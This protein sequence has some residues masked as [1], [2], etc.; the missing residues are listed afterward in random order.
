MGDGNSPEGKVMTT[1]RWEHFS[2]GGA[3]QAGGWHA[4]GRYG[5]YVI[6][7]PAGSRGCR[8]L[9]RWPLGIAQRADGIDVAQ[10]ARSAALTAMAVTTADEGKRLAQAY[11]A[12]LDVEGAGPAWCHG[13]VPGVVTS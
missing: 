1:M 9:A 5:H 7:I 10:A 3:G 2:S 11:E 12:G 13:Y 6:A 8:M 4:A